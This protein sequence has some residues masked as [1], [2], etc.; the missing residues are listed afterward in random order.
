MASYTEAAASTGSDNG[1]K[2][3]LARTV[4]AATPGLDG[5]DKPEL[6]RTAAAA[7]P[8]VDDSTKPQLTRGADVAD[9]VVDEASKPQLGRTATMTTTAPDVGILIPGAFSRVL[10]RCV[11]PNGEPLDNV[12]WVMSAGTFP[13]A[14]P[15][16]KDG[17]A[18]LWLLSTTYTSFMAVA[19]SGGVDLTWYSSDATQTEVNP[20][21]Q[22]EATVVLE[23][24]YV[25]GL[26]ASAGVSLGL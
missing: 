14:A 3:E 4:A 17:I 13:T 20:V 19:D 15:V 6:A 10:V 25:G 22:D 11:D 5:A 24:T 7:S 2:P 9:H 26:N 16:N 12:E 21:Q 1:D 18:Y 8:T 23:P